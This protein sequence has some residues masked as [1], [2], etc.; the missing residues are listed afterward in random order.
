MKQKGLLLRVKEKA[1]S[2]FEDWDRTE[3]TL[4]GTYALLH[5][6]DYGQTSYILDHEEW[7]EFNDIIEYMDE[8]LGQTGVVLYFASSF[9]VSY[10]IADYLDHK[11]RK[12]F[13]IFANTVKI[14]LVGHNYRIG[15]RIKF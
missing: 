11:Y 13:L 3:K 1:G 4:F 9:A 10:F 5:A 8:E 6:I 14:S 15:V 7:Y 2:Y 12:M